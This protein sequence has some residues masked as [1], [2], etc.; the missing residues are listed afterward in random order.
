MGELH[1]HG[2]RIAELSDRIQAATYELLRW[3]L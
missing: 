2:N 3:H 1:L